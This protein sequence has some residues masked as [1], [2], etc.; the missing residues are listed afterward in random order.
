[1]LETV[2]LATDVRE[3]RNEMGLSGKVNWVQPHV[4]STTITPITTF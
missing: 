4:V 3:Y 1:M 2:D